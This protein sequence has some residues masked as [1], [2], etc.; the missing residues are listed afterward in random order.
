MRIRAPIHYLTGVGNPIVEIRRSYDRLSYLHNGI[1]YT[2]KMA[3]L[4]WNGAQG[5]VSLTYRELFKIFSWNLCKAEIVFFSNENFKL[6]LCRCAQSHA[7]GTRK[8]FQHESLTV[9]VISG[10]IILERS[11]NVSETT[12]GRYMRF[13]WWAHSSFV[14]RI[15]T[16]RTWTRKNITL[17]D[18]STPCLAG[19][20]LKCWQFG[21]NK[22]TRAPF[23]NMV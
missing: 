14:C 22:E 10:E 8:K 13:G 11:Q 1:S 12:P 4:Y 6:K 15:P 3:S 5:G 21:M 20:R 19:K 23:I 9:N 16:V 17:F 7:L 18:P 2:G